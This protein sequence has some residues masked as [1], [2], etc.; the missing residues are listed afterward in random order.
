MSGRLVRVGILPLCTA[1]TLLS[2]GCGTVVRVKGGTTNT[3]QTE[4]K[5]EITFRVDISGCLD[6]PPE[7]RLE[8]IQAI[9]ESVKEFQD[10]A[11]ILYCRKLSKDSTGSESPNP[12]FTCGSLDSVVPP[13]TGASEG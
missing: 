11:K 5:A 13:E 3:A 6:I 4:S 10:V 8:C 2:T 9:T 1:L 12:P 7:D